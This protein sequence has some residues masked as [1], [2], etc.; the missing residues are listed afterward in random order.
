MSRLERLVLLLDT[1]STPFIRHTAADQ[2]AELAR[3]HHDEV[4]NLLGRVYPYLKSRKWDTRVAAARAFGGIVG[5]SPAWDPNA[6]EE[7][8]EQAFIK[9][10]LDGTKQEP[11]VKIEE[12]PAVKNEPGVKQEPLDEL[13]DIATAVKLEQEAL[14]LVNSL[15]LLAFDLW[16]LGTIL[17]LGRHLLASGAADTY[18]DPHLDPV[19][20]L[21]RQKHSLDTRLGLKLAGPDEPLV[22]PE[23][24]TALDV[25]ASVLPPLEEP[26][27]VAL[28]PTP[29][30]STGPATSARL[31]AMARRRAKHGARHSDMAKGPVDLSQLLVLLLLVQG[32]HASKTLPLLQVDVTTSGSKV[33]VEAKVPAIPPLLA[34]HASVALL[35]WPFQGVYELLLLDLF[36]EQWET[37]HGA[38]LGLREL[39]KKHASGAGRVKGKLRVENDA[40]NRATL[41]DLCVRICTLLA[42]DRFGDYVSDTV[43]A[44]VRELA[45]QTLAAAL[46]HMENDVVTDT[47]HALLRLVR[48]LQPHWE[49]AH[50]GMLGLR[51]FVGVR[52]DVLVAQPELLADVVDIVVHGL[53][54]GDDDVQAAAAATLTPVA[55]ELV[56]LRPQQVQQVLQVVWDA[57]VHLDDDLLAAIGSVMDL[58]ARLCLHPAVLALMHDGAL[59]L[60]DL[61]VP[62]LYPF[63][64]HSVTS[65]RK[66]VLRTL[67]AF[68][69]LD[70]EHRT[71]VSGHAVRLVWQNIL[72]ERND[73]VGRL[74][75]EVY[76]Q[77]VQELA[78]R[79]DSQLEE[80][81]QPHI[82]PFLVLVLTPIGGAR[83]SYPMDGLQ[84]LR[85]LGSTYT[86][87][88]GDR[89]RKPTTESAKVNIDSAVVQGDVTIVGMDTLLRSRVA[90]ATGLGTTLA[91]LAPLWLTSQVGSQLVAAL[92]SPHATPRLVAAVVLQLYA[93]AV[94]EVPAE[95]A[96]VFGEPLLAALQAPDLLPFFRE[97]V[98]A[99]KAVRGASA[100]LVA[101]FGD[102]G[103][104]LHLK[105]PTLPV[106]VQGEVEAG[107]GAFA[108]DDARKLASDATFN[109]M[110][111]QLLPAH[112]LASKPVL[113]D[114]RARL[115]LAIAEADDAVASRTHAVLAAQAAAYVSV[116]GIPKKLNPIIRLL[117]DLV[118]AEPVALLQRR[119]AA[120]VAGVLVKLLAQNKGQVVDKVVKNI[121]GFVCVD[122]YEVPE[123]VPNKQH[124]DVVLL[125]RKD[126]SALDPLL[127]HDR[128]VAHTKRQGG[129]WV[130]E[131]LSRHYKALLWDSVGKLRLLVV[132]AVEQVAVPESGEGYVPES[133]AVGQGII[134]GLGVLRAMLPFL[135]R[136]LVLRLPELLEPL[137][138]LLSLPLSVLRYAASKCLAAMC[139]QVPSKVF[140][141]LVERVLPMAGDPTRVAWRQGC[142]ECVFH[143][144]STMGTDILPYVVFFI[145]PV[146]GRMSDA[147]H[148]VRVLAAT[149]FAQIIK[150]VP[151][152]AGIPDPED[153]PKQLLAGRDKEREFIQQ[154]MDPTKVKPFEMPVAIKA[155]LR[156]Y[157]QEG[158]NWLAF[159]NRYH[160][161]GVLCD[162]MGLGKTLQT[163]CIVA[164]DHHQRVEDKKPR[165]PLLVVCPP[166]LTGH[167]EQE[168]NQYAPFLDVLVY[169][170]GLLLRVGLRERFAE[171]DI[172]VTLYD[173][174]RND[175]EVVATHDYNY[176]VLDEG[177]IIKNAHAKLTKAVKQLRAEHRLILTGTPIQNNVVELWLLFD[178]L[179]PGYLGPELVFQDKFAK[180]I[181]QLRNAKTLLK[182]QE[183]GALALELL[184]RQVL[185]FML[186]RLKEDVLLDLPPKI[187]QDYYC[188]LSDLQQK[189]YRDFARKQKLEVALEMQG[190]NDQDVDMTN[191]KGKGGRQH[192][193]QA[194]QYMRKLCNH[195]ALVVTPA[196]P[197]YAVVEQYLRQSKMGIRDIRH[198]P[199]LTALRNLLWECGIGTADAPA[200]VG[201]G[202]K[203]DNG[204][205]ISQ[206]RV[207]VF[208]QLK[209]MLEM[210]EEDLFK[211]TMPSVTYMRLD[212]NTD[213]RLRQ[214]VVRQFNNDPLIDVLLLTTKV[215]G[216]GLNL[217][218]ADT[219][220]FV[221]HDW[222]PMNDLQAM[223]RA[224]RLGQKKVVNV[225]RLITRHT[226][227]EKIMGLQKFKMNIA[228]TVV[229]QQNAGLASMDT[230]QL[231]DLF[232][233]DET[234]EVRRE[235]EMPVDVAGVDDTGLGGKAGQAVGELAQLWDE[236]EYEEEYNLDNFIKN[237]K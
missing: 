156:K 19:A 24:P 97:L 133:D 196:H 143:L 225:Y 161:H 126:E 117:M 169:V 204:S 49:A 142:V 160:L 134:D 186:R 39:V 106:V 194:L 141:F 54:E 23:P 148:D 208:C 53:Q 98:P 94:A 5:E 119:S 42:L 80:Q 114:A 57:L 175:I 193:F 18:P 199:K 66:A 15:D 179:M 77:L 59:T 159:L 229:N 122:T 85:P 35:V 38:A 6:I 181:A 48:Q 214:D 178:F 26:A 60:F 109:K 130:L 223:D 68:L 151:L 233:V 136:E 4:V 206:H 107:P 110:V 215:G 67:L 58:L 164:A 25:T 104:M 21:K 182:E 8:E 147:S 209:D 168:L 203:G 205:V 46:L 162:D 83:H 197:Q 22:L 128:L 219:V 63:L 212:G 227:E 188:D 34:R 69:A 207:L 152:E 228:S 27:S 13:P 113:D 86:Q 1:G 79:D 200:L 111:L 95:A 218:G 123:Y 183:R 140:P 51:Y 220:I 180:P 65:V 153:M 127:E 92:A 93:E 237:L 17:K 201:G 158:V 14:D 167:W 146:L 187:I 91:Q 61:L 124:T 75:E 213:P 150:L 224:H 166:S 174:C 132:Q 226:L 163:I 74:L 29:A 118:R 3:G 157:Q 78:S 198:A 108:L 121:C 131:E 216:L 70:H 171:A 47:F 16:D 185:P 144:S 102:Q 236:R 211:K 7:L 82:R 235:G 112:R 105:L 202:G 73:E 120:A 149:T 125:L 217:T 135:D 2:L 50:G 30:P 28:T 234:S 192:V 9:E 195:P 100:Q 44:P 76:A 45:A 52:T 184:H 37:R 55:L 43:V 154:M 56:E 231:L 173:V 115:E 33:V 172:V 221:E 137:H 12:V 103:R 10:E 62:R 190:E 176:C 222:N 230:G 116:A 41:Q 89:K 138:T 20:G 71:W 165:L 31:R 139:L 81:V 40:K 189:L 90:A 11:G 32:T 191:T 36:A 210:V 129:L 155:T 232:E 64:R 72:L 101:S 84:L 88:F 99:L 177:H 96:L 145:V 170:G 87:R